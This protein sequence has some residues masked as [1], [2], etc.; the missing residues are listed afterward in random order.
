MNV[1]KKKNRNGDE[2]HVRVRYI[3][4]KISSSLDIGSFR[5]AQGPCAPLPPG[6][7]KKLGLSSKNKALNQSC[8]AVTRMSHRYN[9][10]NFRIF[11]EAHELILIIDF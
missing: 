1:K 10:K 5:C 11:K 6:A 4:K 7:S 2:D 8:S 3:G 9:F